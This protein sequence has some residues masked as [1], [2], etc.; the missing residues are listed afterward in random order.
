MID[1]PART[2]HVLGLFVEDCHLQSL[3]GANRLAQLRSVH[4]H[5]AVRLRQA[6]GVLRATRQKQKLNGSSEVLSFLAVFGHQTGPHAR[7]ALTHQ[8][9]GGLHLVEVAQL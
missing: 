4:I 5:Q 3:L 6:K 8:V 1:A 9:K 7:A 2:A